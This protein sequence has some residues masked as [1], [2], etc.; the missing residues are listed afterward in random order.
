MFG[1]HKLLDMEKMHRSPAGLKLGE[2]TKASI[3]ASK[4]MQKICE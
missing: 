4:I 2:K 3:P 1:S